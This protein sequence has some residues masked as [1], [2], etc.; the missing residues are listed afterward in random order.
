VVL[1]KKGR[2]KE[3]SIVC[4]KGTSNWNIGSEQGKGTYST[5]NLKQGWDLDLVTA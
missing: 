4:Y 3:G 1:K 5:F 2:R